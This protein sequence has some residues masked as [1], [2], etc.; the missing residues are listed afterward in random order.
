MPATGAFLLLLRLVLTGSFDRWF[1]AGL[2]AMS[3]VYIASFYLAVTAPW[4]HFSL[5]I[6]A[7]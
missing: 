6:A 1:A 4:T 5:Q 3:A 7:R 2:A